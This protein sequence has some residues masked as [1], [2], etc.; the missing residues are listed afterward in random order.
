VVSL[1]IICDV[2]FLISFLMP[3]Y[4]QDILDLSATA[5]GYFRA[6]VLRRLCLSVVTIRPLG[7]APPNLGAAIAVI[8]SVGGLLGTDSHWFLPA[9]QSSSAITNGIF[10][11]DSADRH[12]EGAPRFRFAMNQ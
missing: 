4:L 3:F 11:G 9:L 1:L 2:L 6:I 12:D 5:V 8:S 7:R 10:S